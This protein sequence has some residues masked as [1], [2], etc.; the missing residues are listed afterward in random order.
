[1]NDKMIHIP[2]E[3]VTT[4]IDGSTVM[5]NKWWTVFKEG[6][7]SIY[8]G[9][10]KPNEYGFYSTYSPQCNSNE[11]IAKRLGKV[12]AVFLPIVY[13]ENKLILDLH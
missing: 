13:F 11:N 3:Q 6:H 5:M 7:I 10:R 9:G 8:T 12:D 4:P 2:Y 1:M